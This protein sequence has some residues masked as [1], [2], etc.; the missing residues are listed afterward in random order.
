L[1]EYLAHQANAMDQC[2]G[3]LLGGSFKSQALLDET[4]ELTCMSDANLNPVRPRVVETP[5]KSDFTSIQQRFAQ[6]G[7]DMRRQNDT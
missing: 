1:N 6:L 5:E 2:K 7:E 3:R 4:A